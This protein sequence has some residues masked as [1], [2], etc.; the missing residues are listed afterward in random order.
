MFINFDSVVLPLGVYLKD[1]IQRFAERFRHTNL[2]RLA[3]FLKVKHWKL[4]KWRWNT[5]NNSVSNIK[6]MGK[7]VYYILLFEPPSSLKMSYWEEY[8]RCT[9]MLIIEI[10]FWKNIKLYLYIHMHIVHMVLGWTVWNC[11]FCRSVNSWVLAF[12]CSLIYYISFG[13]M[14][15]SHV[16]ERETRRKYNKFIKWLFLDVEIIDKVSFFICLRFSSFLLSLRFDLYNRAKYVAN[17]TN[18]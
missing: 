13:N 12:L 5:G 15:L 1:I 3:S 14:Y 2:H 10:K 17:K 18:Y 16:V 11:C 9:K 6:E 4:N 8:W 7:W